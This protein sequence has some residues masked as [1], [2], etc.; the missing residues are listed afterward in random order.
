MK[1][2]KQK[3]MFVLFP[4]NNY[5]DPPPPCLLV[6]MELAGERLTQKNTPTQKYLLAFFG[7]GTIQP[8]LDR[9]SLTV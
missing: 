3:K 6:M 8:K 9:V 2:L 4:S 1:K 7:I 5:I